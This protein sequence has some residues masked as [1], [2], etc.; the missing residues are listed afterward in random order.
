[1]PAF[2][3]RG[4][5]SYNSN[6]FSLFVLFFALFTNS[7]AQQSKPDKNKP[8][9]KDDDVV[10][11]DTRLVTVHVSVMDR[12]GKFIPDIEKKLFH[13]YEDKDEQDI[14]FFE[15]NNSPFTVVLMLDTSD[16]T[17]FK[18]KDIQDAAIAFVNQLRSDDRVIVVAFDANVMKLCEAT[19]DRTKIYNAILSTQTGGGTSLYTAVDSTVNNTLRD[20]R[21]R[22]AIV[23]FTDGIDT[24]SRATYLNTLDL[25]KESD[26]IIYT[27]QYP[28]SDFVSKSVEY[29]VSHGTPVNIV[30]AKGESVKMAYERGTRYLRLLSE[31]TGGRFYYSDTLN[32][33]TK[34]FAFIA[35]ELSQQYSVSYYPK[36]QDAKHANRQIKVSVNVPKAAV[37]TRRSYVFK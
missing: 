37:K 31:N 26:A 3:K 29:A 14:D 21:G 18:L 11:V 34:T 8:D 13:I 2:M 1:M 19:N 35:K 9:I 25:V 6:A 24:A 27:I 4:F 16:S 32:S 15:A 28:T 33:L 17:I 23:L 30:T 36:N 5:M 7:P 10:R 22:K 12:D 20:I